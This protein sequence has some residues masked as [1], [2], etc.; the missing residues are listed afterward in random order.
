[1]ENFLLP[2]AANL[3]KAAKL[4]VETGFLEVYGKPLADVVK[5]WKEAEQEQ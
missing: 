1:M 5:E 2:L 4:D 3:P